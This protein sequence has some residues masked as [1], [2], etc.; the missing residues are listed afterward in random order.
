MSVTVPELQDEIRRL[1][2]RIRN[3]LNKLHKYELRGKIISESTLIT[4]KSRDKNADKPCSKCKS[5]PRKRNASGA[6][7]GTL[8]VECSRERERARPDRKKK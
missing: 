1:N 8:C 4:Q 2:N 3:L 5:A 7:I 6:A